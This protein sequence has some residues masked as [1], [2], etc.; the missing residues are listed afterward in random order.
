MNNFILQ[1]RNAI[2]E[3]KL[4]F[5]KHKSINTVEIDDFKQIMNYHFMMNIC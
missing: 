1:D 5:S 3:F 2:Y 4:A